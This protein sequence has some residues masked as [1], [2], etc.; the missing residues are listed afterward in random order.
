M[1]SNE[2]LEESTRGVEMGED[3]AVGVGLFV[4]VT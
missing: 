1:L 3:P 4:S 2:T